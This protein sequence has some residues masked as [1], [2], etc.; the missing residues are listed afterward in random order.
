MSPPAITLN[1]I[2]AKGPDDIQPHDLFWVVFRSFLRFVMHPKH[3]I[4]IIWTKSL[5][6]I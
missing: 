4:I 5:V 3:I 1:V 6:K 2:S